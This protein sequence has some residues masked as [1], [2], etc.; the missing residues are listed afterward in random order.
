LHIA[1]DN[2]E[3]YTDWQKKLEPLQKHSNI[4]QFG[5]CCVADNALVLPSVNAPVA[6]IFDMETCTAE[7]AKVGSKNSGYSAV[8]FDGEDYWFA[9]RYTDSIVKWNYK[10]NRFKEFNNIWGKCENIDIGYVSIEYCNGYIWCFPYFASQAIKINVANEEISLAD[11]FQP[12]CEIAESSANFLD[13]INYIFSKVVGDII[14]AH[15]GK[16]NTL[17]AYNTKTGERR[18]EHVLLD[19]EQMRKL[20]SFRK[21]T[22]SEKSAYCVTDRDHYFDESDMTDLSSY[23]DF[24]AYNAP[25]QAE[26]KNTPSGAAGQS[27]FTYA[28]KSTLMKGFIR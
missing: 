22:Y 20:E 18:E 4:G 26:N 19:D 24:T 21:R 12:E 10:T 28:A 14:Y 17:I 13:N 9:P 25:L 8:C 15:T 6:V 5:N 16:S 1:T 23:I 27:I 11:P 3:S 2:F 7:V